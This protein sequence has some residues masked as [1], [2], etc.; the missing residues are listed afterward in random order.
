MTYLFCIDTDEFAHL[1]GLNFLVFLAKHLVRRLMKLQDFDY[2][3]P[4][5]LV[6]QEPSFPRDSSRLLVLCREDGNM[7]HRRFSELPHFLKK[8]DVVVL[9]NTKACSSAE[10]WSRDL[11]SR[12]KT[13]GSGTG[14]EWRKSAPD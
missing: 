6:A 9:N 4:K 1:T 12:D 10:S 14:K 5:G 8:G 11:L 3:L 7:E 2:H 13:E